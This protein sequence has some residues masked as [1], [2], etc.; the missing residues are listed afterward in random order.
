[1]SK[2]FLDRNVRLS[3]IKNE[4]GITKIL[5]VLKENKVIKGYELESGG[6]RVQR[7]PK[8]RIKHQS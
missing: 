7:K 3:L 8:N 6:L 5:D 4:T 2:L 1:M